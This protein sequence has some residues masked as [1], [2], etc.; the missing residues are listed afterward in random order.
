MQIHPISGRRTQRPA[1]T[2][3][4]CGEVAG[5]VLAHEEA[6][7][8]R[9]WGAR[10]NRMRRHHFHP[11]APASAPAPSR[12]LAER[13]PKRTSPSQGGWGRTYVPHP[14]PREWNYPRAFHPPPGK[15]NRSRGPQQSLWAVP[16][17]GHGGGKLPASLGLE[18]VGRGHSGSRRSP[19]TA[20]TGG[21]GTEGADVTTHL[22]HSRLS[23]LEGLRHHG[24][25]TPYSRDSAATARRRGQT[26]ARRGWL[27]ENG[28]CTE[29]AGRGITL[30]GGQCEA[31][32]GA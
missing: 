7:L 11:V 2:P 22:P 12:A 15:W 16:R 30:P 29:P 18:T 9:H 13:V 27:G 14:P 20:E 28:G 31:A 24:R 5:R 4:S 23:G 6:R 3:H 17:I 1:S 10:A 8:Q 32:A 26:S 25:S 19:A 21:E